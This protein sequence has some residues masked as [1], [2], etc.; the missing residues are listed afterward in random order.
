M[1]GSLGLPELIIILVIVMLV[2]GVGRVGEIG[3]ELG[4]GIREFKKASTGD[5]DETESQPAKAA[6]PVAAHR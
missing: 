3:K 1:L 2:F 4:K 5:F 6:A